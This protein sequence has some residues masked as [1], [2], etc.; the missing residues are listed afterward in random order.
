MAF[1]LTLLLLYTPSSIFIVLKILGHYNLKKAKNDESDYK[2]KS[3]AL[4]CYI[5]HNF[6]DKAI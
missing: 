5:R 2:L 3:M 4:V 6:I 1:F